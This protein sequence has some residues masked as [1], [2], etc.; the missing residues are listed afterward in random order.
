MIIGTN[1]IRCRRVAPVCEYKT[2]NIIF[3]LQ[4]KYLFNFLFIFKAI[5]PVLA[6]AFIIIAMLKP[7]FQ[8]SIF[9]NNPSEGKR[10]ALIN[11]NVP[12]FTAPLI[13]YILNPVVM[14]F[15]IRDYRQCILRIAFPLQK[16]N[17]IL[18]L[19][20]HR[21]T[22]R[23]APIAPL[24]LLQIKRR[25]LQEFTNTS[26]MDESCTP[27]KIAA[28]LEFQ[29]RSEEADRGIKLAMAGGGLESLPRSFKYT[30][31]PKGFRN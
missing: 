8:N 25:P 6:H 7:F 17:T 23:V 9:Y 10:L 3:F 16:F 22:S 5:L 12:N 19:F 20:K 30:I 26:T 13:C 1:V 21:M 28:I 4:R 2:A 15:A 18:C 31:K 11:R 27:A 29:Q 24:N 14:M